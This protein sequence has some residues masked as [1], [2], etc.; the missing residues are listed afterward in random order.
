MNQ[1]ING[2]SRNDRL[3]F[4]I[5][6]IGATNDI[7]LAEQDLARAFGSFWRNLSVTTEHDGVTYDVWHSWD[8]VGIAYQV[9]DVFHAHQ[10]LIF[11]MSFWST[12]ENVRWNV[13][14]AY[15]FDAEETAGEYDPDSGTRYEETQLFRDIFGR[16]LDL[17]TRPTP[18][19]AQAEF[20]ARTEKFRARRE[21]QLEKVPV[22]KRK[23]KR[24]PPK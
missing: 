10:T 5:R 7:A 13:V 11:L 3:H 8:D 2:N 18:A 17:S 4:A 15:G 14:R 6:V 19:Q 21:R 22:A 1:T 12:D 20:G 9:E 24:K 23:P 16:Y